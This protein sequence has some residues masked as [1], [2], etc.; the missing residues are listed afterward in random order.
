MKTNAFTDALIKKLEGFRIDG[1]V[2]DMLL[3]GLRDL[4]YSGW[5][6]SSVI[7]RAEDNFRDEIDLE[8]LQI[9][10][11]EREGREKLE[12]K[13]AMSMVIIR[14]VLE[15]GLMMINYDGPGYEAEYFTPWPL[16]VD[17]SLQR[18]YDLWEKAF[19]RSETDI[20]R[21]LF[22]LCNT[23]LGSEIGKVAYRKIWQRKLS[24]AEK[25]IELEPD[26]IKHYVERG[27]AYYRL[28]YYE[29]DPIKEAEYEKKARE[30][31]ETIRK[32]DPD[33]IRHDK[34]DRASAYHF[35]SR[36]EPDEEKAREYT[37]KAHTISGLGK[38]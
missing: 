24:V 5:L 25:A 30:D 29:L 13:R 2:S 28:T 12:F 14:K 10:H 1:F 19:A 23:D 3:E 37:T 27:N 6:S 20:D 34:R 26:D 35:F 16:S 7:H 9:I 22:A 38:H 17:D 33:D 8:L 32:L 36:I 15:E 18:V 21:Y 4:I 11:E 31:A